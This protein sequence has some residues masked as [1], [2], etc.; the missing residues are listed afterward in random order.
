MDLEQRSICG[1][2]EPMTDEKSTPAG[3]SEAAGAAEAKPAKAVAA[4]PAAPKP[5]TKTSASAELTRRGLFSWAAVAWVGFSAAIGG[6]MTAFGRFMFPNVLFEPPT[7]FKVGVPDDFPDG[8]VDEREAQGLGGIY[9]TSV[10]SKLP[11]SH[12]CHGQSVPDDIDAPDNRA[13]ARWIRTAHPFGLGNP[14]TG[15]PE[16]APANSTDDRVNE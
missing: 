10:T 1:F 14:A 13:I 12:I 5:K 9:S 8:V 6:C 11:I 7:S 3:A 16:A 2:D 4:K 15:A